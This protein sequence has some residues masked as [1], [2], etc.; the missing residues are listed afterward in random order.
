[1]TS[2]RGKKTG[3]PRTGNLIVRAGVSGLLGLLLFCGVAQA[4][5]YR[6]VDDASAEEVVTGM[7]SKAARGVANVATGW[8]EFPKQIYT[9]Y[10]EDGALQ[11]C[12]VGPLK[13]IGMTLART[14]AGAL[15]LFTFFL[16][17]PGFYD[18]YIDPQYVWEMGE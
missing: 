10:R 11:G 18:P 16:A 13:G 5:S 12:L 8:L 7:S 6:N 4:D 9:T 17:Y 14:T 3:M 1:M 2:W 15:E